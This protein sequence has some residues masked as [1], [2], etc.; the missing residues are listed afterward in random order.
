LMVIFRMRQ[1]HVLWHLR[2]NPD[3]Y[4]NL[5]VTWQCSTLIVDFSRLK[6][7]DATLTLIFPMGKR[8]TAFLPLIIICNKSDTCGRHSVLCL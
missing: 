7:C 3:Q 1:E 4:M 8:Q 6:I 5:G 2:N